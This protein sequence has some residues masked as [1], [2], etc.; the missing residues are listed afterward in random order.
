MKINILVRL[1]NKTFLIM[2][3]PATLSLLYQFLAMIC[4]VPEIEEKSL[5][6]LLMQ[7]IELLALLGIIVDPTTKG[8]S[9]SDRAMSYKNPQ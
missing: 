7:L 6:S 5:L 4:F 1:R 9:D 8:I 2:F 3:I